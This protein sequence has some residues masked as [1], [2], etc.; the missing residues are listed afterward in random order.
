M[1]ED[2]ENLVNQSLDNR[3][4]NIY[5][6]GFEINYKE[7]SFFAFFKLKKHKEYISDCSNT[8]LGWFRRGDQR[9]CF[10]ATQL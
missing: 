3:W 9:G 2:N 4:I 7:Y 6:E 1:I 8:L 5:D 10:I